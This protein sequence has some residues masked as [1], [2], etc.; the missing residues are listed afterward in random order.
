M[1]TITRLITLLRD[2]IAILNVIVSELEELV[3]VYGDARKTK[4]VKSKLG[5]FSEEDLVAKE[6]NLVAITKEGYVKR[7]PLGTYR[8]QRRGGKGVMGMTTKDE[9]EILHLTVGNTH[10]FALFFTNTGKVFMN[11]VFELPEGSRQ[12]KGQAIINLINIEQDEKVMALMTIPG[13]TLESKNHFIT[14]VT[15]KGLVKK[16]PISEYAS[17]RS[18][19]KIGI[20]LKDNDELVRAQVTNGEN[21]LL[22][23][24][25]DGKSIKFKESDVNPTGRDTMG[26]KGIALKKDDFVIAAETFE[27]MPA[28]PDDKRRKFY[29]EILLVTE[30]GIG[31]RTDVSEYPEQKRGGQGVKVAELTDKTGK[32]AAAQMV[33]EVDLQLV[34]TTKSAQVIKLPMKN[35]KVLGRSTQGVILMRPTKGDKVTSITTL[36][37]EEEEGVV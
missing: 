16:T 32:V 24:T 34:M 21:Y 15:K 26:V 37:E 5:E 4:V 6:D 1:A 7:M 12:A 35:I 8:S 18:G 19:G 20:N 25:R 9:D 33:S 36:Q 13:G 23:V 2:P 31:K 27:I 22:L 30:N 11:R 14:M 17:I 3:K 28:R 29:R 10:D